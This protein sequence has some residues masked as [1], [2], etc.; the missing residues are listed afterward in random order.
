M[1]RSAAGRLGTSWSTNDDIAA[2]NVRV[3]E[4]QFRG[5]GDA[6]L[7]SVARRRDALVDERLDRTR[8]SRARRRWR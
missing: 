3:F 2:S 8:P 1:S 6:T 7:E 4:R 5:E